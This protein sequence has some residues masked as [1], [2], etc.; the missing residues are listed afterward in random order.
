VRATTTPG[1]TRDKIVVNIEV[2]EKPTGLFSIGGGYSSSDG[3][4]GSV[5]LSQRNFLGRG[6]EVFLRIR[7]GGSTQQ[8][9]IGFTE[10]W[11]FDRPLAA[12]FDLFNNRR[13]YDEYTVNSLGGDIR[14]AH[15]IGEFAR[16]NVIYRVSQDDV[17]DV[18]DDAS[19][20]LKDEEGERLTSMIGGSLSW[21]SRDNAFEPTRGLSASIGA[22]FAGLAFG[23][24]KFVRVVGT[25]ARFHPLWLDHVLAARIT[26]GYAV[27]WSND[28]V[29]LFERFYLGGPNSIRSFK[30]RHVSPVDSSNTRIGGNIEVLGNIEYIIPLFFGIRAALFYDVGQVYGPDIAGGD[31]FDITKVRHAVGIGFRWASP[32][33]PLRVD[34]GVNADRKKGESFGQFHFSVGAPF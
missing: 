13:E 29:P 16:W 31:P 6:W 8:G 20:A 21:D 11:L 15:P 27:G 4:I 23:D 24:S 22:D 7:A 14:F 12:G 17:S 26:L 2:T 33:G 30:L 34:Y 25:A 19:Q 28:S 18:P 32:F 5:D 10:P 9:T 1:S 3:L